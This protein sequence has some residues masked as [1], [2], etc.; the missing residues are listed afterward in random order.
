M[1]E[2]D[3][4]DMLNDT[5]PPINLAGIEYSFGY[6]LKEIDPIRFDI[7]YADECSAIDEE[8]YA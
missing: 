4:M 5:Y 7:W 3:F 1:S 2:Q 6:A 8:E